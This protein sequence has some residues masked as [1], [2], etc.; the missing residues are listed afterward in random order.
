MSDSETDDDQLAKLESLW[1]SYVAAFNSA[2]ARGDSK[3]DRLAQRIE[4]VERWVAT[5]PALTDLG[6][7]VKLRIIL[8]YEADE[9]EKRHWFPLLQSALADLDRSTAEGALGRPR[10]KKSV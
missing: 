5:T 2:F 9:P 6:V 3:F 8:T 4:D 1:R 10:Q 7:A